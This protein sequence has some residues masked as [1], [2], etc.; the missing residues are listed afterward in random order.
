MGE[1]I[2]LTFRAFEVCL[3]SFACSSSLHLQS[4]Q[5]GIFQ[6]HSLSSCF[7]HC[8]TSSDSDHPA[9][10]KSRQLCL[11]LCD[12]I[13]GSPPGSTVPGIL[14]TRILEWVAMSSSAWKWKAKVKSLSRV[15][16]FETPWAVAYQA[17]PSTG[18]SILSWWYWDHLGTWNLDFD[19]LRGNS[20]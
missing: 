20:T 11:T 6:F 12:P 10:A 2:S 8:I 19:V 18:F 15:W 1:S 4:Q 7:Y 3:H 17:P 14:Q 13:D 16:L 5:H 9:A